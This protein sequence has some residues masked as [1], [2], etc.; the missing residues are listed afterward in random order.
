MFNLFKSNRKSSISFLA[1]CKKMVKWRESKVYPYPFNL[2]EIINLSSEFWDQ[3]VR[4]YKQT[5]MDGKERAISL[6]WADDELVLTSVVQGDEKSVKSSHSVNVRYEKHPTK[7]EYLRKVLLVDGKVQK[8]KEIYYKKVPKKI[9]V[10]YLFNMH[11]HPTH[12]GIDGSKLYG[13]F[14]LQDMKSFFSSKAVITGLVTDRLWLLVRTADTPD[15]LGDLLE[16]D[17]TVE[18]LKEKY[19]IAIYMAEFKKNALKQ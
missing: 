7:R 12:T 2:P 16:S 19:S 8:K 14:S 4:I 5:D 18:N 3:V 15:T 6:F 17:I 11:T 10:E 13:F 9:S 1:L